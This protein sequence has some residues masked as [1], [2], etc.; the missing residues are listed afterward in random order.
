MKSFYQDKL[1]RMTMQLTVQEAEKVKLEGELKKIEKDSQKY[2]ELEEL[3]RAKEKHIGQL[4]KRQNEVKGLTSIASRNEE[5]V[6]NLRTEIE[7]MK[8]KK[9]SLEHQLIKERKEHAQMIQDLQKKANKQQISEQKM[10]RQLAA[11]MAQK[12]KVQEIAK[13]HSEEIASLRTKYQNA[14]KKLRMQTLKRGMM[15][16]AGID[17]VLVGRNDNKRQGSNKSRPTSRGKGEGRPNPAGD[18]HRLRDILDEKI[19]EISRKEAAADKLAHEWEDHLD[20]SNR[21]QQLLSENKGKRSDQVSDEIEALDFQIKYKESRIRQL[22]SKLSQKSSKA[23]G[24]NK[25]M[26]QD[27]LIDER[28][29][30]ALTSDLPPLAGAQLVS[31]V[32]FGMVIRERR[33]VSAL[34]RAASKLDGEKLAAEKLAADK[35][36]ALKALIDE[37]KNERVAMAQN[38]NEKILSLMEIVQEDDIDDES[39]VVGSN[40]RSSL[41]ESIALRLA[42]ERIEALESQLSDLEYEKENR[43]NYQAREAETIGELKQLTTD[44][45]KLLET[46]TSL[47]KSLIKIKTKISATAKYHDP[48]ILST[49]NKI[50]DKVLKSTSGPSKEGKEKASERGIVRHYESDSEVEDE[51]SETPEWATHIMK[52]LAIIAAGDVPESLKTPRGGSQQRL[53]RTPS[54]SVFDRLSAQDNFTHSHYERLSDNGSVGSVRSNRSNSR[55]RSGA[56]PRYQTPTKAHT[57]RAAS[58][59]RQRSPRLEETVESDRLSSILKNKLHVSVPSNLMDDDD[60]S[61]HSMQSFRSI[62]SRSDKSNRSRRRMIPESKFVKAYTNK[63]VFERLQKKHTNSFNLNMKSHLDQDI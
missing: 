13:A 26:F 43:E 57:M 32:L 14:E 7:E 61:V 29:L 35:D 15:E 12:K 5:V 19:L 54:S 60:H 44:Y 50:I 48:E 41:S 11:T 6:K 10:R 55:S 3:L 62:G 24:S 51:G 28:D 39:T 46:S 27:S 45:G 36:S 42:N 49:I 16:R 8:R 63:N 2:I 18:I 22:A 38:Q 30:K 9:A 58:P 1:K 59:L 17:P 52:D 47:R 37:A 25:S 53:P 33:R 40:L 56:R 21:K 4:K 34:A 31:R 23:E 20:L